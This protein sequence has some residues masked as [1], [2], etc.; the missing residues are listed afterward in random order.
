MGG[1]GFGDEPENPLLEK[2]LLAL[3]EKKNPRICFVGTA[4]GDSESYIQKFYSAFTAL[5]GIP[6]HIALTQTPPANLDNFLEAQDLIY[7][8]GGNTANLIRIWKDTAFDIAVK[9]AYRN[10]LI[11]TGLSAGMICWFEEG[12]TDSFGD[13]RAMN[14]LGILKGSASPH[15]DSEV[16][17]RPKLIELIRN[18]KI[19]GGIALDDGVGALYLNENLKECVSS[20][21]GLKAY[22]FADKTADESSVLVNYLGA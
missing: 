17:R 8:G 5:G 13:L 7:V 4:S 1:G 10:G 21:R 12:T 3:A 22:H 6:S 9:K 14:C 16:E 2:Y 15:F 18:D 20:H 19:S 11:L